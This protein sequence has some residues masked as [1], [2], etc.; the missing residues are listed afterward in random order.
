MGEQQ[1]GNVRRLTTKDLCRMRLPTRYW[2]AEIGRVQPGEHC[3]VVASYLGRVKEAVSSGYGL[4]LWGDNGVG[5][6]SIAAVIAKEAM[7]AGHTVYFTRAA[8]YRDAVFTGEIFDVEDGCTVRARARS[9]GLLVLD[10][11]GKEGQDASGSAERC[12]EDLLR[13]RVG[14]RKATLVTTNLNTK[15]FADPSKGGYRKSFLSAI[16]GCVLPV[17]VSG[18]DLRVDESAEMKD[19][20]RKVV[21]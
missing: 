20:L 12:F 19:F 2:K 1:A 11:I 8:D 16:R 21:R 7:R 17:Q 9:V 5:K 10:D 15:D 6:T 3:K 4:L 14:D 13:A 18:K